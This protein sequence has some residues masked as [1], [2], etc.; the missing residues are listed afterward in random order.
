[1]LRFL[2]PEWIEALDQAAAARPVGAAAV[3]LAPI[4][5]EH[6]VD[7]DRYHVVVEGGRVRVVAGASRAATVTF[8]SDRETATAIARGELSAQR[9][10]MAGRLRIGG[11]VTALTLTQGVFA[12]L[13]DLF[14]PVRAQTEF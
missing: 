7:G 6:D 12:E 13:H 11:D 9:A 10:F 5:V 8:A 4:V 2:S 3:A 14:A 1:V